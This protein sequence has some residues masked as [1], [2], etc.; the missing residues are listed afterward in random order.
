MIL[1]THF[2]RPRHHPQ[3]LATQVAHQIRRR[4]IVRQRR[5][6][7]FHMRRVLLHD[8]LD[9]SGHLVIPV[10]RCD[11]TNPLVRPFEV[12]VLDVGPDFFL[13]FFKRR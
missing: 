12:V 13:G 4:L 11:L 3:L 5:N 6:R 8:L 7:L 1:Q 10:R 9:L 2:R